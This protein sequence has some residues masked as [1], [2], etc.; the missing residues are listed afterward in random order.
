MLKD[1]YSFLF[2]TC[3]SYSDLWQPFFTLLQRYWPNF[4]YDVYFCT[5]SKKF[6]FPGFNIHCPL[7]EPQS[8][9]WSQKLMDLLHIIP[10]ENIIFMLD[11]FWLKSPVNTERL[12]VLMERFDADKQMGHL[13]MV[14]ESA[15]ALKPSEK[16]PDLV[17]F[18]KKRPYRITAQA[19]LYRRDYLLQV[20]RSH[21]S[22][23]KFEVFGSKR[24]AHLPQENYIIA[25]GTPTIFA[26]DHGGVIR[27]GCYIK[28][29]VDYF[30]G[31]EGIRLNSNRPVKTEEQILYEYHK[32]HKRTLR[33][34]IDY[35]RSYF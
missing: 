12:Q 3:D 10:T 23:W 19:S 13:N 6:T 14:L 29:Y 15:S 16:Y 30:I 33:G 26:Y 34:L 2:C 32:N 17:M 5:E 27:R 28:E 22:A 24:S 8:V 7:N 31:Y 9:S 18:P 35:I 4:D 11:D 25:N 1:K 21:E 20:L